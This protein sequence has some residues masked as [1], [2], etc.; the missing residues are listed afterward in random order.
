MIPNWRVL[1]FSVEVELMRDASASE[2]DD[3]ECEVNVASCT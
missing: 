1:N 2:C 3:A